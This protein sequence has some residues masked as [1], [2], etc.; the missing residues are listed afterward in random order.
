V[1]RKKRA[2]PGSL[3]MWYKILSCQ[4]QDGCDHRAVAVESRYE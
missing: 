3:M 4:M 1:A 2:E